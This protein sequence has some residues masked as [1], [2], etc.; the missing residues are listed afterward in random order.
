MKIIGITGGVGS[1]K[2]E[3]IHILEADYDAIIIEAD[4]VAHELMKLNTETYLEIVEV[5]GNDILDDSQQID[6]KKLG[7]FVFEHQ[8]YIP[9]LNNIIHPRVQE[10]ILKQIVLER[11]KANAELFV[12]EAALLIEAGYKDICDELWY[13]YV[14]KEI[15]INRLNLSRG[16]S[17]DK[18]EAIM[19]SQKDDEYY[20][21]NS[22][23][24]IDN[25]G[26]IGRTRKSIDRI[27]K[28]RE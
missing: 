19:Q 18:S 8:E 12:I 23:Y 7:N 26:D 6:R 20:R 5:F 22:D 13:I 3:I 15:R 14:E 11:K 9:I 28:N 21:D 17:R 10:Y 27:L 25:S 16:Y 2:S 24:V 4:K 1:G